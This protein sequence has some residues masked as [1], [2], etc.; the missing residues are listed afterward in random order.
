MVLVRRAGCGR[1]SEAGKGRIRWTK[2][3]FSSLFGQIDGNDKAPALYLGRG[4]VLIGPQR[5]HIPF[6]AL[7]RFVV[8][9][10]PSPRV[11]REVINP[12]VSRPRLL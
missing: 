2:L 9:L 11:S 6:V 3:A 12:P 8:P 5:G 4:N 7:F 1:T 10:S